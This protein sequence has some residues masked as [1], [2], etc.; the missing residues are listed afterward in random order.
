M[1]AVCVQLVQQASGWGE[2]GR[3]GETIKGLT[4]REVIIFKY[5]Q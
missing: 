5:Y 3:G 2:A 4:D 1:C